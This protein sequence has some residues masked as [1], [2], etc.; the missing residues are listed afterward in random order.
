MG[1][2][3]LDG[4]WSD[5]FHHS[6][7]ALL[8]GQNDGYYM[9]FGRPEHLAKAIGDVFVY[10]G[11]YSRFHRRRHGS[12]VGATGPHALR[13]LRAEPRPVGQFG[14]RGPLGGGRSA[15]GPAAGRAGC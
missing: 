12:R 14:Q 5:D 9:D 11:C 6:L 13:R 2:Y 1:G 7:H 4:V 10:D 3:G 15:A 8:T